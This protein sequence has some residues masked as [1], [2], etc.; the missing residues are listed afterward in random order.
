VVRFALLSLLRGWVLLWKDIYIIFDDYNQEITYRTEPDQLVE[1]C[2]PFAE[3]KR[4]SVRR[5]L[6]RKPLYWVVVEAPPKVRIY[7]GA[8]DEET[9][10]QMIAEKINLYIMRKS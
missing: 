8:Y 4:V 7:V 1:K 5:Q 10:A 6:G 2:L 3:I 9:E